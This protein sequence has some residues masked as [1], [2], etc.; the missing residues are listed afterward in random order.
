MVTDLADAFKAMPTHAEKVAAAI[1]VFGRQGQAMVP[2]LEKGKEALEEMFKESKDLGSGLGEDFYKNAK[3][4]REEFEHFQFAIESLKERALAAVLPYLEKAGEALVRVGK[5]VLEITKNT[6]VL[7]TG[8]IFL[9]AVAT[10]QLV[11][12]LWTLISTLGLLSAEVL[13]PVVA[14]A[15]LYLAFDE[16]YTF[17][18]GGDSILGRLID[19][20]FGV[21]TA[22]AL[23][24]DNFKELKEVGQEA[25]DALLESIGPVGVALEAAYKAAKFL[26]DE[27]AHPG[28]SDEAKKAREE[29]ESPE[30]RKKWDEVQAAEKA[31]QAKIKA[32]AAAALKADPTGNN[33]PGSV[34]VG[35]IDFK[36]PMG[37]GYDLSKDYATQAYNEIQRRKMYETGQASGTVKTGKIDFTAQNHESPEYVR[38]MLTTGHAPMAPAVHQTNNTHV[39]ITVTAKSDKPRE[40]ANELDPVVRRAIKQNANTLNKTSVP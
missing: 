36:D 17:L 7:A 2:I 18:Q 9:G 32:A 4:V 21:G 26:H 29:R 14:L 30:N 25:F 28:E 22:A 35:D 40:I 1:K 15:L 23:A 5:F 24:K 13:L 10:V 37:R 8:M 20:L 31:S 6:N 33:G 39:Q 38:S 11:R 3:K 34:T 19:R 16:V 27:W 12:T